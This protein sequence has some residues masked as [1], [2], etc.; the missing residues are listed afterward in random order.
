MYL[1]VF[2]YL[3]GEGSERVRYRVEHLKKNF[4]SPGVNV[5]SKKK[6]KTTKITNFNSNNNN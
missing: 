3:M 6:T 4:I 2:N 5:A 1:L